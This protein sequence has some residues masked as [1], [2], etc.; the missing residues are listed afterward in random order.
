[1][2]KMSITLLR[3]AYGMTEYDVIRIPD[4]CTPGRYE[5]HQFRWGA[6]LMSGEVFNASI[7]WY[8]YSGQDDIFLNPDRLVCIW[9]VKRLKI[10][11]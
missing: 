11:I 10:N 1:M 5:F 6:D 4:E 9:T 7:L 8:Q 2:M 3:S